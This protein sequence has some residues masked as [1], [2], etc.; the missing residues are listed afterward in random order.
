MNAFILAAG[1]GSRISKYIPNIPKCT[2]DVGGEPLI[3]RTVRMLLENR[4]KTTVIVGYR[5]KEIERVLSGLPVQLVYNP[6][7]DVTNSIGSL[8][9]AESAGFFEKEDTIVANGD[10]YWSREILA[11]ILR[12]AEEVFMLA[13]STRVFDGD[14]FFGTE[15]GFLRRY[16]KELT[17]EERDCE[18]TGIAVMKKS[19]VPV[20]LKRLNALIDG[21]F[22][23]KWWEDALYSLCGERA[24]PVKDIKGYFWAEVDF[25]EDYHRILDHISE[26][27]GKRINGSIITPADRQG[28]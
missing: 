21:Q 17:L 13:D 7:Y 18:Y 1:R 5:H 12:Q 2:V 6:F 24:I 4:I 27:T 9:L 20:F 14:Y 26:K 3:C 16:G 23:G 19:F 10:V 11:F 25:I 22:H 15:N 8:W 28:V